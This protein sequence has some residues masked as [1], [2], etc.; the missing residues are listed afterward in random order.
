M[1]GVIIDTKRN[2]MEK[3]GTVCCQAPQGA[4]HGYVKI[5]LL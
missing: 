4:M 5:G 2:E 1:E 3:E